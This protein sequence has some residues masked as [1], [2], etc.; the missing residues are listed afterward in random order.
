MIAQISSKARQIV[1]H[2]NADTA[3]S[4]IV[5]VDGSKVRTATGRVEASTVTN[6]LKKACAAANLK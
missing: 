5:Q 6:E 1:H 3:A 4:T 2:W